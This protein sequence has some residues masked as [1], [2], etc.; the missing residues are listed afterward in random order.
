MLLWDQEYKFVMLTG[1]HSSVFTETLNYV[2]LTSFKVSTSMTPLL[3]GS[4]VQIGIGLEYLNSVNGG[5]ECS[6]ILLC[7]FAPLLL[8]FT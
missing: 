6:T 5:L 3:I 7:C 4:F 8:I 2:S 1:I